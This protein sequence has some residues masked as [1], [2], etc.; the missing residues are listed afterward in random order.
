[1]FADAFLQGFV[2]CAGLIVAIGAQ[3]AHVLRMG[4]TR[5]HVGITIL[6][7]L[8]S[9]A[10]LIGLGVAGAGVVLNRWPLALE[11]ATW[12][13]AAFLLW[14]GL[15]ALRAAFRRRQLEVATNDERI[16][17]RR[18]ITLLLAFTYLNPHAYVDTI[19]LIGSLGARHAEEARWLFW[20]G[21][22]SA[23]AVWFTLLGYGA[24]WLAPLFT[25]PISWRLLDGLIGVGMTMLALN[26]VR[27]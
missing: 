18:A 15:N 8:A 19:V 21:C 3:N 26:L 6:I 1:M 16:S 24:R 7:C 11:V 20:A 5:Q 27:H 23:S 25:R 10:L 13:G 9:D 4:L 17:R 14:Y 2:I 22:V 12:G